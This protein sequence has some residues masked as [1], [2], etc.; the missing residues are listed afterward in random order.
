MSRSPLYSNARAGHLDSTHLFP[1]LMKTPEDTHPRMNRNRPNIFRVALLA[2]GLAGFVTSTRSAEVRGPIL[3][4][5]DDPTTSV[6]VTW[7]ELGKAPLVLDG[8]SQSDQWWEGE[9][10]FGYGDDDDATPITLS[11]GQKTLYTRVAF[12]LAEKPTTGETTQLHVRYDDGFIA[13]LNGEEIARRSVTG[14]PGKDLRVSAH[15]AG[16]TFEVVDLPTWP[17]H[18]RKGKNVLAI[19]C[20]N[21]SAGSSDMTIDAYLK[22]TDD[23]APIVAKGAK[24]AFTFGDEPDAEWM[25]PGFNFPNGKPVTETLSS[26]NLVEPTM[27]S[28]IWWRKAGDTAWARTTGTHRPFADSGHTVH[29][30]DLTKLTP[31]T[32]YEFTPVTDRDASGPDAGVEPFAFRSAPDK[33]GS[34]FRFVTGG[35]M[36]RTEA[37]KQINVQAGKTDPAFALL[38]GDLAYANGRSTEAWLVWLDNWHQLAR[39]SKGHLIPM[40]VLIGN[41]EMGSKLTEGQAWQLNT[42]PRSKFFYSLFTFPD[43]KPSYVVDFG[44]YLSIYALDSDHSIKV[45][46]QTE[47]LGKALEDRT[48]RKYQYVCYHKPTYGT[49]K[50]PNMNVRKHWV[51]L[52]EKYKVNAVFENDHHTF[53]RT[54]PILQEKVDEE[55]GILYLG[56]GAW[57]A[58]IRAVPKPGEKWYLAKAESRNHFWLVTLTDKAPRYQAIDRT[59]EVFD[60]YE[61]KRGWR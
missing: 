15:E 47:W 30:V 60:D 2:A 33:L 56:D 59:G 4:W 13:Y 36:H 41:H 21:V 37:A 19:V 8:A 11:G 52:F 23:E 61:D 58:G 50:G 54:H 10:G 40:V 24:W 48:N 26:I 28:A 55:N 43:D 12:D 51:P 49:A 39:T 45:E 57:G 32:E 9:A 46:D 22:A 5:H 35:D 53:K 6:T 17:K 27:A 16:K 44:D 25:T 34:E 1:F 38:G 14:T 3:T 18:A 20:Y 42:H 31:D 7:L 29:V